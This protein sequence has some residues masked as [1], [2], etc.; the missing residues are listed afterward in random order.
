RAESQRS[1][2]GGAG[3]FRDFRAGFDVP[4]TDG[5]E[6]AG[7]QSAA[8]RG[9]GQTLYL[10]RVGLH[11]EKLFP[12][13]DIPEAHRAVLPTGSQDFAVRCEGYV[14]YISRLALQANLQFAGPGIANADM[15]IFA[16]RGQHLTV[17]GE[18][19]TPKRVAIVCPPRA[20]LFTRRR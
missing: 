15:L 14:P 18:S 5:S 6:V 2:A 1:D 20:Q 10:P 13:G 4:D 3:K 9:K 16:A 8:V 17:G 11:H 12:R 7:E 19:D